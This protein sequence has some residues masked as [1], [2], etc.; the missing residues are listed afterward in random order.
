MFAVPA[1]CP[2]F[3]AL[4]TVVLFQKHLIYCPYSLTAFRT[5]ITL[6]VH[7]FRNEEKLDL[8]PSTFTATTSAMFSFASSLLK[9]VPFE[10]IPI[11]SLAVFISVVQKSSSTPS[12][13]QFLLFL[14][15]LN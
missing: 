11:L 12:C 7:L 2:T 4:P 1:V 15:E 3:A 6:P 5:F 14:T 10:S 8:H 9:Q 13:F